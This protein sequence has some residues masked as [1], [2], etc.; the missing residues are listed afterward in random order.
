MGGLYDAA[1][2]HALL[3]EIAS[4]LK[5]VASPS[6]QFTTLLLIGAFGM[7]SPTA[8]PCRMRRISF[9]L[10]TYAAQGPISTGVGGPPRK[11]LGRCEL[12]LAHISF[13]FAGADFLVLS[14]WGLA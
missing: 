3:S 4:G 12:L 10:R 11:S 5:C 14:V 2:L 8:I 1:T 9:D 13:N 7:F 6:E